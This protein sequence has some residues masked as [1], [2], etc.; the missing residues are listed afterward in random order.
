M[1]ETSN[2]VR[3]LMKRNKVTGRQL[4]KVLG[5]HPSSVSM[6]LTGHNSWTTSDLLKLSGFFDVSLDWLVGRSEHE[7][8][9]A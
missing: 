9:A 1:I 8:V 4:A 3:Q 7:L 5:L 6:K 2:R